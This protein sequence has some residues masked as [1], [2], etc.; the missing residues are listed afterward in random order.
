MAALATVN[1]WEVMAE[2]LLEARVTGDREG[3][4]WAALLTRIVLLRRLPK[5]M[6]LLLLQYSSRCRIAYMHLQTQAQFQRLEDIYQ[7]QRGMA[8][9]LSSILPN[10]ATAL[11]RSGQEAATVALGNLDESVTQVNE[12]L[13]ESWERVLRNA[14]PDDHIEELLEAVNDGLD[15][16][17]A[18][19]PWAAP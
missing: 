16:V 1:V 17:R 15:N 7:T 4:E 18:A 9:I 12:H 10:V 14:Q 13:E 11:T 3:V 6:Q 5:L 19:M 2:S 8:E